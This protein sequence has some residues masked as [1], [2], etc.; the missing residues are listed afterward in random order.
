M[1]D[2]SGDTPHVGHDEA[3]RA[4]LRRQPGQ[5]FTAHF[6]SIRQQLQVQFEQLLRLDHAFELEVGGDYHVVTLPRCQ[7][8]LQLGGG[9]ELAVIDPDA[10][11]PLEVV[12]HFGVY[13]LGP[14]VHPD[15]VARRCLDRGEGHPEACQQARAQTLSAFALRRWSYLSGQ[16]QRH[17]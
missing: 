13:V 4:V 6:G 8:S 14:V 1:D 10:G 15:D 7:V 9:G 16:R 5:Q 12:N 17:V 11:I 2:Q 3:F